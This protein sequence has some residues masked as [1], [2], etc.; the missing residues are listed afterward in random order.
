MII[1]GH[2]SEYIDSEHMYIVDGVIVPSVTQLL[3]KKFGN[4]YKYVPKDVLEEARKKGTD[5]H[6]AI[7]G[8][9][10][11][12][13][14]SDYKELYNY[15]FL[16]RQY[17]FECVDN[18]VP[19]IIFD[20]GEPVA[21]GRLDMVITMNDELGLADIKR[22]SQLDKNYLAYQLNLYRIGFQQCYGTEIKFLRG[23]HLR[24]DV[25]KF[26]QIPVNEKIA[27]ELIREARTW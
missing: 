22:T 11:R 12:G 21:A 26:V 13:E 6:N 14:E 15:R 10:K 1:A 16:K 18:E 25:R 19:I 20:D 8:F 23:L 2:Y 24:E 5:I 3:S 17:G 7:E 27:W 9:E 4:K